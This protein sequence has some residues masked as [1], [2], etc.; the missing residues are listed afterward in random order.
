MKILITGTE[1]QR[2]ELIA[3]LPGALEYDETNSTE[4]APV[5]DYDCIF[6][7]NIDNQPELVRHYSNLENTL[8]IVSAVKHSLAEYQNTTELKADLAGLNTLN[9]FIDRPLKEMSFLNAESKKAFEKLNKTL[10]W[11]FQEIEDRVGM[12]TPRVILMIINEACYTLQ[13]GTAEIQDIDQAMKLGTN[14]PKGPFEWADEIGIN[15][16]YT[17]LKAIFEDTGDARYKICPLLK[18]KYLTQ[19]QFYT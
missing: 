15:D 10:G 14:Y 13:E 7:L 16:V 5:K 8:L 19:K 2:K 9:G 4:T 17:T 6:D 18:Q 11:E 3:T 12:V 1:K